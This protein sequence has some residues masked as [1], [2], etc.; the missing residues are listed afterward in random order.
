LCVI[1]VNYRV[2]NA[3]NIPDYTELS[4]PASSGALEDQA[5]MLKFIRGKGTHI[6]AERVKVQKDLFAFSKTVTHGFPSKPTALSYDPQ[7]GLL[8]IANKSGAL[9]IVGQPGVEYTGQHPQEDEVSVTKICFVP[10]SSRLITL[11][12]DNSLHLWRFHNSNLQR[13][14]SYPLEGKLKR[15]SSIIVKEDCKL[16]Y[17]GTEGG[18]IYMLDI[19]KFEITDKIIYLDVVLQNGPENYK[20]NPGAVECILE[21]PQES[22]LLIGYERGLVVLWDIKEQKNIRNFLASQQLEDLCWFPADNDRKMFATAHNDGS[23]MVWDIESGS[24]PKKEAT[25]PYGPFPCKRIGKLRFWKNEDEETLCAFSGGMPRRVYGDHYTI[26]VKA[27]GNKTQFWLRILMF[28]NKITL[29][30]NYQG[31]Q[32]RHML[33]SI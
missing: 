14:K 29:F 26:S 4:S 23:Y 33:P 13:V 30:M 24:K 25:T 20:V 2:K 17:I 21:L 31:H 27:E 22:Q 10:K 28:Q 12:D 3:V 5:A 8:A 9:T 32:I 18:N 1:P 19:Q 11:C 7:L 6:S 16:A 15:I